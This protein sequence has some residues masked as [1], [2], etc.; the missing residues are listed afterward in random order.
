MFFSHHYSD[1]PSGK[2]HLGLDY[3]DLSNIISAD[4]ITW[5][6]DMIHSIPELSSCRIY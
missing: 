2:K 3:T 4:S 1:N 6:S 5:T